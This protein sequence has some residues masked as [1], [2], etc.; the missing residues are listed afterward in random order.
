MRTMT[1]EATNNT[2]WIELD[3]SGIFS[4][5]GRFIH[6]EPSQFFTPVIKWLKEYKKDPP[7]VTIV[8]VDLEYFSCMASR[9]ILQVL[10]TLLPL[11]KNNRLV[12][13]WYYENGDEDILERGQY[14][15]ALFN[16]EFNFI[17]YS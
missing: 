4:F 6:E 11:R 12:I 17:E 10:E 5:K 15:E 13:N 9:Y 2:P 16:I 8:N 1:I 14:Y 3:P 7:P